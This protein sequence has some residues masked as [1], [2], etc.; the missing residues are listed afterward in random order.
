MTVQVGVCFIGEECA[1]NNN[2]KHIYKKQ[3]IYKHVQKVVQNGSRRD[4]DILSMIVI[5]QC[6][7]FNTQGEH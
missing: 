5:F 4:S 3:H 1:K 2:T 7:V 6:A